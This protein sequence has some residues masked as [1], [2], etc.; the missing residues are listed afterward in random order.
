MLL[1]TVYEHEKVGTG[2]ST[3]CFAVLKLGGTTVADPQ[4]WPRIARLVAKAKAEGEHTVLVCSAVAGVTN[5]LERVVEDVVAGRNPASS[6][7]RIA[8][9][10]LQLGESLGIDSDA[11]LGPAYAHLQELSILGRSDSAPAWQASVLATGELMSTRLAAHWLTTMGLQAHWVD[12]RTL[13]RAKPREGAP[14]RSAYLSAECECA[15]SREKQRQL[16]SSDHDVTVTQGFIASNHHAETV[17]LGRG[18]SDT[19]AAYLASLLEAKRLEIWTDVPGVFTSDPRWVENARLVPSLSYDEAA[20]LGSLGA[21]VLH[22]RCLG[23]V[24][25]ADIPLHIR[26]S[27]HPDVVGT[28]INRVEPNRGVRAVTA[29][30]NLCLLSMRRQRRWQPVGFMASVASCFERHRLSMDLVSSSPSEIRATVDLAANPAATSRLPDLLSDLSDVCDTEVP[31]EVTSVSVVGSSISSL[32][33]L[34]SG[35][36]PFLDGLDIHMVAHAADDSHISF[37]VDRTSGSRLAERIHDALFTLPPASAALG[38][39]WSTLRAQCDS[40]PPTTTIAVEAARTPSRV[41]PQL[42]EAAQ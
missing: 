40:A 18:G 5:D 8:E 2:G 41:V 3:S 30:E 17:L 20:V 15:A 4:T 14:I 9:R 22:P 6:L 23:P 33:E 24:R 34:V 10:H 11:V 1:H 37:V 31:T 28:V 32:L 7:A 27:Q 16:N 29:R 35:S 39:R 36:F 21:K 26:W 25:M 12:A 38:P 13:L 19:S 42:A